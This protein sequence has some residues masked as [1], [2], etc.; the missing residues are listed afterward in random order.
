V[1]G[2]FIDYL[3]RS[4][5]SFVAI[6]EAHCISH[7]GHDFRP[8]YR[9]LRELKRHFPGISVHAYTA[10][11][12]RPV[13]DDIAVQL[14]LD[15]PEVIVGSFD[16]PNL[17]FRVERRG[18]EFAQIREVVERHPGESGIVYC[19]SRKKVDAIAAGLKDAGFKA[20][21]YHAGMEDDARRRNQE[22]FIRE[23]VDIIVATV[24][25]GMGIDK[26][27]VRYVAHLGMPKSL[28]HYQQE[29]GRAGR[30]GLEAECRL[31]HSGA[32]FM[33]WKRMLEGED[34]DEGHATALGKLNDMQ[35]FATSAGCRRRAV[36]EYFGETYDKPNCGA[37]DVCLGE[38]DVVPNALE[39]AQKIL[40]CV[41]RLGFAA[42]PA[43]TSKVLRG[44]R[45]QKI[46]DRGHDK[47][48]T[49]GLLSEFAENEIRN[50]VEQL[51]G[52]RHLVKVGDYGVLQVTDEGRAVLRGDDTPRLL[53]PGA[54]GGPKRAKIDGASWEGVDR[55]LFEELRTLRK[56]IAD[57]QGVPAFVVFG[58][59]ALRDMAR[60]RPATLDGFLLVSGV[61]RKKCDDLGE[62]FVGAIRRYCES[63]GL[64][65]DITPA[66]TG[67][68]PVKKTVTANARAAFPLFEMG[69]SIAEV[70]KQLG[71]AESTTFTYLEQY[72]EERGITAPNPWVDSE[73]FTRVRGAVKAVGPGAL[74]PIFLHLNEQ[75]PYNQL[76]VAVA[77]MR[78]EIPE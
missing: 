1:T 74:K 77:C 63:K 73:L 9:Q 55:G 78:N 21:P 11:A 8:E 14:Q 20:L 75:V 70:A 35:A 66:D 32:D 17:V 27:N 5:I 15:R 56:S 65:T 31:F 46:L 67:S 47:L 50:W 3:K 54:S 12:T 51:V 26:S 38:A 4:K 60:R 36:L 34:G 13:R 40:S 64:D 18:D 33:L 19:I 28:E 10:T 45:E 16:R 58:D 2:D 72:V 62:T 23:D 44:A 53:Q 49:W 37:C 52:Q 61:G 29:C 30:D 71:R 42:G 59:A 57:E 68:P 76:R 7:W 48:S 25:F 6:D 43:Y 39:I 24:A 69:Y 41:M 22:A